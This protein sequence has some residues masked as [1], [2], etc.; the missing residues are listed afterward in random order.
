MAA[1]AP[2]WIAPD[3]SLFA[4]VYFE[5][6]AEPD[7][8][9]L[10]WRDASGQWTHRA[11]WGEGL[12]LAAALPSA[13]WRWMGPLPAA[14]RWVRLS[15]PA[16][17]VNLGGRQVTGQAWLSQGGRVW[18]SRSGVAKPDAVTLLPPR[19][20]VERMA[21]GSRGLA[22]DLAAP[23]RVTVEGSADLRRWTPEARFEGATG[24]NVWRW[25][26]SEGSPARWFRVRGEACPR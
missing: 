13:G 16:R 15:V 24:R 17:L 23:T 5:P 8:V 12:E 14:G 21:T 11:F 9:G 20:E 4:W 2:R 7:R 22:F 6:G 3:S 10:E 26:V 1:D 18:W 25:P 19:L